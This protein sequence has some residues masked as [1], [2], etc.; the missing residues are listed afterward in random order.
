[1]LNIKVWTM[2]LG[3]WMAATFTICV[4]GGVIA[5]N[6]P[7]P[8]RTLELLLPGFRW[9]SVG[10]FVLGLVEIFL[11]GVCAGWLLASLHNFFARRL[12]T[13]WQASSTGKVA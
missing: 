2:S 12:G 1:M 9:I 13:T 11:Y 8:H 10:S 3:C 5:P 7:I 4:L 6:L